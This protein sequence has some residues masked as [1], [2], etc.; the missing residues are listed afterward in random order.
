[1]LRRSIQCALPGIAQGAMK[2]HGSED[3]PLRLKRREISSREMRG[4]VQ[5]SHIRR[6]THS[7][8]RMRKKKVGLLRSK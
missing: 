6:P 2:G 8:E 5:R 4:M 7:R 3:P 1:M